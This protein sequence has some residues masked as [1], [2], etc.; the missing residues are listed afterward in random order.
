MKANWAT[1]VVRFKFRVV[2]NHKRECEWELSK[3]KRVSFMSLEEKGKVTEERP[4]I[5]NKVCF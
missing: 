2:G 5:N 1:S 4:N 3:H